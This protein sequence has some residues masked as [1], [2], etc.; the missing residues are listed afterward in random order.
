MQDLGTLVEKQTERKLTPVLIGR[1]AGQFAKSRSNEYDVT[2]DGSKK[3]D[4][5]RSGIFSLIDR[6]LYYV[7]A[8]QMPSYRGDSV[9]SVEPAMSAREPD[10]QKL[11]DAYAA[12]KC[13]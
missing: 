1:I 2:E 11:V 13:E 9:N 12:S 10:P 5:I 4:L 7:F 8:A 6:F 3:L